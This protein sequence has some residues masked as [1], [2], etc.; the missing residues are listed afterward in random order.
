MAYAYRSTAVSLG[1]GRFTSLF[2]MLSQ[3]FTVW[4]QRRHLEKLDVTR[5]NDLGLTES[6]ALRETMRP[7]WDLPRA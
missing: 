7:I 4:R 1:T 2:S 5:L 6:Q 3:A